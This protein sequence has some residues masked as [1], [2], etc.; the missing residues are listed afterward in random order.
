[1]LKLVTALCQDVEMEVRA[2]MC[3]ELDS[4]ARGVGYV[5][6]LLVISLVLI[7]EIPLI[8]GNVN[9]DTNSSVFK[10]LIVVQSLKNNVQTLDLPYSPSYHNNIDDNNVYTLS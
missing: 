10:S 9:D 6:S 2:A 8:L 5:F 1:M 4:V 7:K 3:A